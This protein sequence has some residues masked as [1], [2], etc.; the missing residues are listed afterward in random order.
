MSSNITRCHKVKY[1]LFIVMSFL[2]FVSRFEKPTVCCVVGIKPKD[3]FINEALGSSYS[4][5]VSQPA[6][7]NEITLRAFDCQHSFAGLF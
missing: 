1:I 5:I 4:T 7:E 6:F 2:L 3:I